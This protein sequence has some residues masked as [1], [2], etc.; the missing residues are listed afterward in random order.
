LEKKVYFCILTHHF[1]F[2]KMIKKIALFG[3]KIKPEFFGYFLILCNKLIE[4]KVEIYIYKTFLENFDVQFSKILNVNGTYTCFY[5]LN[6]DIDLMICVG[7]DGTF[8]EA[9]TIV[10]TLNIPI[11]GINS[12]RL[13]FLTN[14]SKNE[15]ESSINSIFEGN[16]NIES[17]YLLELTSPSPLFPDFNFALNDITVH[18]LDTSSMIEI[19]ALLNENFLNC[20]RADGLIV[21]TSTGSTA[22][23]LSVGGPILLPDANG[24]V[25]SPIA[26]H[27][28]NARPMVIPDNYIIKLTIQSRT[29]NCLISLDHRSIAIDSSAEL[30]IKKSSFS[31]KILQCS[32]N[33]FFSTLRQKLMWG[34]DARN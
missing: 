10:R 17:R 32:D 31:I 30:T 26:P 5:D 13:G 29:E 21:S 12:G 27:N 14:I 22:Y 9:V 1:K 34:V 20:Y 4:E 7:G 11:V 2:T 33:N 25:I 18:K 28:L 19:N 16:Y 8:L 23:S 6:P 15:I 24:F 3:N